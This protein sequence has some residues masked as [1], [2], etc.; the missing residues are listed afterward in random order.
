MTEIQNT[1]KTEEMNNNIKNEI[2][3]RNAVIADQELNKQIQEWLEENP[4]QELLNYMQSRVMGQ[5]NIAAVVANVYNYLKNVSNPSTGMMA[6]THG[7]CNN[8]IVLM[9]HVL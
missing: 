2:R 5:V 7:N 1:T 4:Y 9:Y 3:Q 8:M 6:Q